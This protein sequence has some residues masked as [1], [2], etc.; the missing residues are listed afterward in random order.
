MARFQ[1][2]KVARKNVPGT[3]FFAG[4]LENT[5]CSVL[6][7]TTFK[8]GQDRCKRPWSNMN[9]QLATVPMIDPGEP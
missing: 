7:R 9:P 3:V 1:R 2:A 5:T 8:H 6:A 4:R